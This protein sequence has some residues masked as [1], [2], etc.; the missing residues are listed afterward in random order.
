MEQDISILPQRRPSLNNQI[1]VEDCPRIPKLCFSFE[2]FRQIDYF[3]IGEESSKWFNLLY[4]RMKELGNYTLK[5]FERHDFAKAYRV[6]NINWDNKYM[7]ISKTD[8][9]WLPDSIVGKEAETEMKQFELTSNQGRVIG[10]IVANVFYVVLLDPKHNMQP[11]T[12]V[13]AMYVGVVQKTR[14]GKTEFEKIQEQRKN[15]DVKCQNCSEDIVC[16]AMLNNHQA[17]RKSEKYAYLQ[18]QGSLY[19][20]K[21]NDILNGSLY[22]C[23]EEHI[24]NNTIK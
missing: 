9:S 11:I 7:P 4:T 12:K 5:D 23:I 17:L 6:H 15:I 3:G 13:D 2:Y 1:L 24:F 10:F 20:K 22:D 16:K 19:E 14:K 21:Y 8:L 18:A